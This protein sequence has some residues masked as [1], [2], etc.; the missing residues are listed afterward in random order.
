MGEEGWRP[1]PL[2]CGN[3]L[4]WL[5]TLCSFSC[6]PDIDECGPPLPV[7]CGKFADCQNT[8]GSFYCKCSSGYLLASGAKAFRSESENTCQDVDRCQR[9]PRLCKGRSICINT[10]GNYTCRCPPGLELNL[11]DPNVCSDVNECTSGQNPCH[12]TTHCLNNIGSYECR[13]LPGWKPIPGSP[14]GPNNTV[15]EDVDECSSRPPVCHNS[16]VC[17]NTVGSYRCRCRRGWELKPG[18]QD[19]QTNT[20]CQEMS[21]PAWTEPPGIKS[22]RLSN[23]FKKVQVLR[24]DFKPALAQG[25]IQVGAQLRRRKRTWASHRGLGGGCPI[26][27]TASLRPRPSHGG[28]ESR[29]ASIHTAGHPPAPTNDF[30]SRCFWTLGFMS[31]LAFVN[32]VDHERWIPGAKTQGVSPMPVPRDCG[33][34]SARPPKK[35]ARRCSLSVSGTVENHNTHLAPGFTLNDLVPAPA[36]V[37]AFRGLLGPGGLNSLYRM[38]FRQWNRFSPS[39]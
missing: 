24:R 26:T 21:F 33:Q 19:K 1:R 8:E 32:R 5:V 11:S 22:Q 37:A 3:S 28:W 6:V 17:V 16:T 38:S 15:C 23:F 25:T 36:S 30:S 39:L 14:N 31:F 4:F 13:C 20:T 9:K 10:Q 29:H 35:I 7:S 34:V 27:M 12:N 2:P 18:F